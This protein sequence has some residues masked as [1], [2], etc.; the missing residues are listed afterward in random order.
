MASGMSV[1]GQDPRSNVYLLDGTLLNDM[2]NGPAGQCRRHRARDGD[3]AGVPRRDQRLQRRVRP[4]ERR[5]DQ[6]AD[7][8]RQQRRCAAA[9]TSSTA[10]TR[11]D[12]KNYF[13]VA[14]KPPFT[15]N[16]FGGAFGGPLRT[17]QAVLLRRLRGAARKPRPHDHLDRARRQRAPR[18]AAR[19]RQPGR[20]AQ[21]RRQRRRRAV[22]GGVSA[23]QRARASATAPRSTRSSSIRRSIS[24]SAR[25]ASTTTSVPAARSS[26]ATRSTTP[27]S[28]CRP[29]TRSSLATSCRA[30]SSS[31]ANTAT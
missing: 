29:T 28:I 22:P 3:G 12:A 2:T 8:G 26:P 15:R 9:S 1:N 19:S 5:S 30:I 18:T 7:Q 25:A 10:T 21:R 4:H 20:A 23:G 24:T 6:R 27:S 11:S 14:G 31:P 16:Q 17:R 13:D